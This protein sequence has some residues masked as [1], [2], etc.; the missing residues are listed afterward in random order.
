MLLVAKIAIL[1][2]FLY[3][4][5]RTQDLKMVAMLLGNISAR[6]ALLFM[7]IDAVGVLLSSVNLFILLSAY[8]I[9]ISFQR[10]LYYDVLA[11]AGFYYTPGGLG[12]IGVLAYFL[13]NEGAG[14]G[15]TAA[16]L[17]ADRLI[18]G[19]VSLLFIGALFLVFPIQWQEFEWRNETIL[20]LL[21]F[22]VFI[23]TALLISSRLREI[24]GKLWMNLALL[25]GAKK[26][27]LANFIITSLIFLGSGIKL[28]ICVWAIGASVKDWQVIVFS[29]GV[30]P[31]L[32]YLPITFGGFGLTESVSVVLWKEAGLLSEQSIAAMIVARFLTMCSTLGLVATAHMVRKFVVPRW[33]A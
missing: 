26:L 16:V 24:I 29:Y 23:G 17:L 14:K 20:A 9:R 27:L 7:A 2:V 25:G 21:F 32:G 6:D 33:G 5:I 12:G 10:L 8:Q 30:F 19:L 13:V 11:T 18:G 28:L 15:S 3:W 1:V 4:V 22:T 31:L